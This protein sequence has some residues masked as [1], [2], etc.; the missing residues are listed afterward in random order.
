MR[1]PKEQLPSVVL[2]IKAGHMLLAG[3]PIKSI[4]EQLNMS[5]N[6]VRRYQSMIDKGGV[7]ALER[8]AVGGRK[9]ALDAEARSWLVTALR[10]SPKAHGFDTDQ[11]TDGRLKTVIA[12]Q[13]GLCFSRVYVRQIIIDLGYADRL[14]VRSAQA[15]RQDPPVLDSIALSW[16]AAALRFSPRAKGFD[17]DRWTNE[18]LRTA[19]EHRLGVRYSRSYVWKIST[20]LGLSHLISK[21]RK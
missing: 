12:R 9:S 3:E 5:T 17:A 18:L 21:S 8:L 15:I 14:T 10:G 13:F 11:W 16:I 4:A 7:A 6:T 2:R 20:D 1:S 19:I